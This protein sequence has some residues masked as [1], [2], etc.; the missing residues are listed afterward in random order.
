MKKILITQKNKMGRRKKERKRSNG[1]REASHSMEG[2]R[3]KG[4]TLPE[5]NRVGNGNKTS[6]T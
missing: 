6:V 1:W 2:T 3:S 5:N 4:P